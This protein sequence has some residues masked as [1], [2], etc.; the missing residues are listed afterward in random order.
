MPS[1]GCDAMNGQVFDY[2]PGY[3]SLQT[4]I[5]AKNRPVSHATIPD[6]IDERLRSLDT[7]LSMID[8]GTIWQY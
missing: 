2:D 4:P 6:C 8:S 3:E 1:S 5:C 7:F